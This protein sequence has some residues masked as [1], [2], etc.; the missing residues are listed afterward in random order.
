MLG[1]LTGRTHDSLVMAFDIHYNIGDLVRVNENCPITYYAGKLAIISRHRGL[2]RMD[3]IGGYYYEV[4]LPDI[5]KNQIFN[6]SELDLISKGKNQ[7]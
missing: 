2:D 5:L 1:R 4:I 7:A 3:T 6:H